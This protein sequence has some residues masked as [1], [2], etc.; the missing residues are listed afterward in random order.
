VNAGVAA[1]GTADVQFAGLEINV[2]PTQRNKLRGAQA[3]PVGDQDGSGVS[4]ALAVL[5]GG[6]DQFLNFTLGEILARPSG[7]FNCYICTRRRAS[8]K[9]NSK[10]SAF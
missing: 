9:C 10:S 8:K 6:L 5:A 1:L 3:V 4:V 7:S 2:I